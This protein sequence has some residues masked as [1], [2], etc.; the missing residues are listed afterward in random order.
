MNFRYPKEEDRSMVEDIWSYCFEPK[1]SPFF[2]YYFSHCYS[3]EHTLVGLDE[4]EKIVAT[5]HLRPYRVDVRKKPMDMAYIVGVATHP[6]ARRGGV[7][8]KILIA[9]LE[10]LKRKGEALTILMPSK[11]GF[12]QPY[13]WELYCHQWVRQMLLED[14]RSVSCRDLR[15]TKVESVEDWPI[16]QRV[17]EVYTKDVTGYA[18][19]DEAHWVRLLESLFA[20]G[21]H[22]AIAWEED[23][24]VGYMYYKLGESEIFVSEMVYATRK[25]QKALFGFLY[26]HRS[27]GSSVRWNEGLKDTGYVMYPDGKEGNGVFPFMMVRVVDAIQAFQTV[28]VASSV[29]EGTELC[30][31]IQDPLVPWNEGLFSLIFSEGRWVVERQ[32]KK[33]VPSVSMTVGALGLLFMGRMTAQ[34]LAYE[35]MLSGD[36][37]AVQILENAYPRQETFINEWY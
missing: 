13:G 15:Y 5:V 11:A 32:E 12:Y 23:T 1:G 36:E 18:L 22:I 26:N 29:A 31:H 7:G 25:G 34:Q 16:L 8:Q 9:S 27:Q 10:E 21:M 19:R 33:E 4:E 37:E 3:P 20:E 14:L 35:G 30:V 17:Y 6:V 24:P 2:D 28:P